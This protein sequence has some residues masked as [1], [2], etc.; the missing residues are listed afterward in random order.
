MNPTSDPN[1]KCWLKLPKDTP[2]SIQNLPYGVFV[3][4]DDGNPRVGVAIG[5]YVLDLAEL[6]R[7]GLISA[8]P[9]AAK[10]NPNETQDSFLNV[11]NRAGSNTVFDK[12]SLN[13]FMRSGPVAWHQTRVSVSKLLSG[14]DPRL[15]M[16][17]ELQ[18]AA[19]RNRADVAMRVPV[20]IGDYTDFYSSKQHAMN[21]GTMLR[22][23]ENALMPNYTHLPIAYHGRSGSIVPSG[24][25]VRRPNGQTKKDEDAAPAFGPSKNLDFELEVGFF[26]GTPNLQG[27]PIQIKRAA[28]H[29][30]G[31]VLVN[32][33]SARDI[34]KWEYQPLGPFNAKNFATTVSPW[35]VSLEAIAPFRC[36]GPAQ[37]PEPLPYLRS[38]G[39]WAFNIELEVLLQAPDMAEPVRISQTN[40]RHMYWNMCQQ[41]AHHTS[42]GCN[43]RTGDLIASGTVSGDA[44]GSYGS[45]LEL[46]WK[47]TKPIKLPNGQ[48]RKFLE[49]GD[50]V[51][52]R[53]YCQGDGFRVGFGDCSGTVLPAPI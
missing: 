8:T 42:G 49:D 16:N 25:A 33:W 37:D 15:Q 43:L 30:F 28:E 21:V 50:T 48:E 53:G 51:I 14:E 20:E 26:V 6:E 19:L 44:P 12:P 2:F 5:D 29:V 24:T 36:A 13:A 22:G 1:L 34:Q 17:E 11:L 45:L 41:L 7:R 23:P 47:G 39:P 38:P 32:D 31:F 46:A 10:Y 52:M 4:P 35:V 40:Y 9:G 18:E 3:P 27:Q